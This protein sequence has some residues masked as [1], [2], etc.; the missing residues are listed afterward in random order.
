MKPKPAIASESGR[1]SNSAARTRAAPKQLP[2][3]GSQQQPDTRREKAPDVS[4]I[5]PRWGS[6]ASDARIGR[7]HATFESSPLFNHAPFNE[8]PPRLAGVDSS[9]F[10]PMQHRDISESDDKSQQPAAMNKSILEGDM[11]VPPDAAGRLA[12]R[13][14]YPG[15]GSEEDE[16][17]LSP[18][19]Y[20]GP[21]TSS[22]SLQY[23]GGAFWA[24]ISGQ[25]PLC[26]TFI[27]ATN[28]SPRTKAQLGHDAAGL[29]NLLKEIPTKAVCD[30]F[31]S[32]FLVGV[33]SI[34]PL[35]HLPTFCRDYDMFWRWYMHSDP[36]TFDLLID[37]PTFIPLLLSALFCG[38]VAAPATFWSGARPLAC[39][40]I[41]TTI[42]QLRKAYLKGLDYC[43]YTR[44]P[45]LNTLVAAIL[46]HCCS[47]PA[48]D[49]FDD[50]SFISTVV[51]VAQNMGLHRDHAPPGLDSTAR[52]TRRHIW[53]HVVC[54][55]TQHFL[56][57]GSQSYCG[58]EGSQWDVQMVYEA[59]DESIPEPQLG[60][61]APAPALNL[62]RAT[63][64]TVF[65]IGRYETARFMHTL[66]N[67]VN[68]CHPFNQAD[69]YV[70]L[71]EYKKLYSKVDALINRLP[72][73]GIPEQGFLPF[74]M[75]SASTLTHEPPHM[76][77]S[78]DP[79]AFTAW[80]RAVLTTLLKGSLLGLQKIFLGHPSLTSEQ[81]D[82]LWTS[83]FRLSVDF[84]RHV[85][86]ILRVQAFAPYFWFLTSNV[87]AF[88]A[89]F[90]ILSY[91]K[92]NPSSQEGQLARSLVDEILK[93]LSPSTGSRSPVLA[94]QQSSRPTDPD[95]V[96]YLLKAMHIES[97]TQEVRQRSM[98]PKKSQSI[99]YK[100]RA[101]QTS[102]HSNSITVSAPTSQSR[103]SEQTSTVMSF[104]P[105]HQ[106]NP[107]ASVLTGDM[108]SSG[109]DF[110]SFSQDVIST[111]S[112]TGSQA[113]WELDSFFD[114]A[115]LDFWSGILSQGSEDLIMA[116]DLS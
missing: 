82:E 104:A 65:A 75:A 62:R 79:C 18:T 57:Y 66:L 114:S 20:M 70:F 19:G 68:S 96:W 14:R 97:D 41:D 91:L 95:T 45:T 101:S 105:S 24:L 35:I 40:D 111:G 28:V 107:Q 63:V 56:R 58:T 1:N 61:S 103:Q 38:A 90:L 6:K 13:Q 74:W 98:T 55:D 94:A 33:R 83:T 32:S 42:D 92:N 50:H 71:G 106:K 54:L 76:D 3:R 36:S 2:A 113:P 69:F 43:E 116:G 85:L 87:S 115:D 51:R 30:L 86:Q 46:G 109:L 16:N 100:A 12:D 49:G 34:Y 112:T 108:A 22:R 80:A 15:S 23:V 47:R 10:Q 59:S 17:D 64:M 4:A 31:V 102:S 53:W 78:K 39:L 73:Q 110:G 29:V 11:S 89:I 21:G 44:R 27:N 5:S 67:R 60:P 84:I 81:N 26:D 93:I 48:G 72:A 88:Q 7:R 37:D 99:D 8:H 77:R 52:E 9:S 25:E